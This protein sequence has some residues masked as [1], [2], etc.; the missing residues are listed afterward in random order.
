M[1]LQ[2]SSLEKKPLALSSSGYAQSGIMDL[3]GGGGKNTSAD[4]SALAEFSVVSSS[5]C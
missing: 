4:T 3:T 1:A 2:M 5:C